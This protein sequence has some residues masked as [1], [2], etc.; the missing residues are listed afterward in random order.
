MTLGRTLSLCALFVVCVAE[1][2]LAQQSA[3]RFK[4]PSRSMQPTLMVGTTHSAFKYAKGATPAR[5]DVIVFRVPKDPKTVFAMRVVGL[6]GERLQ[7]LDGVLQING[8]AVKRERLD[9]FLD[10]E[11]G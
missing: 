3:G 6:P 1:P 9:D 11:D 7:M 10:K 8:E 5:G 4:F 2:V